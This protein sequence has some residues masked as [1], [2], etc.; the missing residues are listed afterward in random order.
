MYIKRIKLENFRNYENLDVEFSKDFNLIYGNNAGFLYIGKR[1]C[2]NGG[3][4]NGW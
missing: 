1:V 2:Y 4:G 3:E